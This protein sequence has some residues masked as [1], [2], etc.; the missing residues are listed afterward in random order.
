MLIVPV[1]T[2]SC[3]PYEPEIYSEGDMAPILL[4]MVL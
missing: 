4:Q 1:Y 2:P 3:I